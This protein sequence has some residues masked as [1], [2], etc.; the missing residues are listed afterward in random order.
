[1]K[2]LISNASEQPIY[3]QIVDQIKAGILKNEL[4]E[5]EALPSIR[6]LAQELQISVITTKRAYE[7][8]EREGFIETVRGKGS[9]IASQNKEMLKEKKLK[10][11]EEKLLDVV[12]ESKLLGLTFEEI[13]EM[14][15]ILYDES[16]FK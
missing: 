5:G 11:I 8:L 13:I 1:M 6:R 2:I 9:F 14:L 12:E 15:K 3:E 10:L 16:N 7:E 4:Q